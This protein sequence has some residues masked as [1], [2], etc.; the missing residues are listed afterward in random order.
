MLWVPTASEL[1]VHCAVRLAP[2]PVSATAEQPAIKL[3]ASVNVTLPVG[4]LPVTV[5]VKV[6]DAASAA[7]LAELEMVVVL[8]AL[9]TTC[10][11]AAL[12]EAVLLASPP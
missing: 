12:V 10:D 2:D 3:P 8:A 6:T 9:L 7:G 5:A 4:A 1:V 11:S